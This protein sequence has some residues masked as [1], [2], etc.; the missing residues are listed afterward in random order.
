[1]A[2]ATSRGRDYRPFKSETRKR[3]IGLTKAYELLNAGLLDTFLIGNRRYIFLDSLDDLPRRLAV[4]T[5]T[6]G[7]R[8]RLPV[9]HSAG[10]PK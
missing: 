9:K 1:M 7:A 3:G 5:E 8:A 6:S 10:E 2:E 4:Q